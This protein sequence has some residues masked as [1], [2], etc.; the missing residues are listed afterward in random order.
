M[1]QYIRILAQN[2]NITVIYVTHY[3]EE[4][5]EEF[6]HTLL[7]RNG[8]IVQKGDTVALFSSESMQNFL[9]SDVQCCWQ[10]GRLHMQFTDYDERRAVYE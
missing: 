4:I 8:R 5:S 7:M 3:A 10:N 2:P 9:E 1:L 6:E